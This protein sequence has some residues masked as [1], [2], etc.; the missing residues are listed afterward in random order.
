MA[1][2]ALFVACVLA[3]MPIAQ[4]G[5]EA[6]AQA[7]LDRALLA[8]GGKERLER[9]RTIERV[10]VQRMSDPGQGMRPVPLNDLTP[11]VL[12]TSSRRVV[13]DWQRGRSATFTTGAIFGGQ[14]FSVRNVNGPTGSF[15]VNELKRTVSSSPALPTPANPQSTLPRVFPEVILAQAL[16]MRNSLV[17]AGTQAI[18]GRTLGL[19]RLGSGPAAIT[20]FID[21]ESGEL[22]QQQAV[23]NRPGVSDTNVIA[24]SDWQVRDGLRVPFKQ[25]VL[26]NGVLVDEF[27]IRTVTV[28][29]PLD[30]NAFAPPVG[31]ETVAAP[32]LPGAPDVVRLAPDVYL[33]RR[34]YNS[35]AVIM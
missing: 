9:L 14:P 11:P 30:E 17:W 2:L 10:G 34:A 24:Y 13:L 6:P 32:P 5:A 7:A 28:D 16:A 18:G 23:T 26:R 8:I 19:V 20:L 33:L 4:G 22:R 12:E 21:L 3:L 25:R 35:V 1:S 15:A 29:R 27:D 31:F